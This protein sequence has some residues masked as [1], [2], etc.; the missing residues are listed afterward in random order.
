MPCTNDEETAEASTR[1]LERLIERDE[2]NAALARNAVAILSQP[3]PGHDPNVERITANF[4]PLV[5]EVVTIPYDKALQ[6]GVIHS[7]ALRPATQR[8]W[9]RAAA[10]VA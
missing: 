2:H 4:E 8:V 10:A 6:T 3:T 9:L 5:R 1:F 7:D